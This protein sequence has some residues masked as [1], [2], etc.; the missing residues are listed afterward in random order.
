VPNK[1][2]P[3]TRQQRSEMAT[4]LASEQLYPLFALRDTAGCS[5]NALLRFATGGKSGVHLAAIRNPDG[6][7]LSSVEAI[8]RFHRAVALKRAAREA[9][10]GTKATGTT[11]GAKEG[12][13]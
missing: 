5:S 9:E 6:V 7:W 11:V 3:R 1:K 2:T 8:L 13:A 4:R 12:A 10:E